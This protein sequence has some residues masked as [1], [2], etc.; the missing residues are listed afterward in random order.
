MLKEGQEMINAEVIKGVHQLLEDTGMQQKL[1]ES[2]ADFVAR[3]LGVSA[4]RAEVLLQSL[5]DGGSVEDAVHAAEIETTHV[6]NDLLVRV[7]RVIGS[8][9]GRIA[10]KT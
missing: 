4:R 10:A 5:H 6:N 7:A 1:E 9:L 8:T 2:F 3:G